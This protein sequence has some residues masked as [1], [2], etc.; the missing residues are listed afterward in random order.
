MHS[1]V[2]ACARSLLRWGL[3]RSLRSLRAFENGKK[4]TCKGNMLVTFWNPPLPRGDFV[5]FLFFIFYFEPTFTFMAISKILV[6]V[7]GYSN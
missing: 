5:A 6:H 7:P 1:S 2:G 3:G 4:V